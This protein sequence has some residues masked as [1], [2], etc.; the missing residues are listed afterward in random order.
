MLIDESIWTGRIAEGRLLGLPG[1]SGHASFRL[2]HVFEL[3][4]DTIS[5]EKVWTDLAALRRAL[6]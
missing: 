2:L 5:T 4:D 3:R 6:S 1:R